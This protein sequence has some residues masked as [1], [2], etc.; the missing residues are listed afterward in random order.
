MSCTIKNDTETAS[1]TACFLTQYLEL[2]EALGLVVVR[3]SLCYKDFLVSNAR[4]E[5]IARPISHS[6]INQYYI[7]FEIE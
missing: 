1:S 2:K 5:D 4:A 6:S 3:S 7:Y